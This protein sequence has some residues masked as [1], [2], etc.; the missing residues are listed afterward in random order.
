VFKKFRK[1]PISLSF[2]NFVSA[3]I[4]LILVGQYKNIL[5]LPDTWFPLEKKYQPPIFI[6][7]SRPDID[8]QNQQG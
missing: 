4:P 3:L 6:I 7:H 8:F 5:I 1:Y 2:L